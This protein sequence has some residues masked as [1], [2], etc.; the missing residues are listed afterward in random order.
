V[1]ERTAIVREIHVYGP[2]VPVGE[3]SRDRAQHR[4]FGRWLMSEAERIAVE[5]LDARRMLVI[6]GVEA[7][8]CFRKLGYELIRGPSMWL[9]ASP[10]TNNLY[11]H[12]NILMGI[13][14]W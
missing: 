12:G 5:E 11:S 14:C 9:R 8:N 7:R 13:L 1:D 2:L 3:P 6:S 4:G 10:D